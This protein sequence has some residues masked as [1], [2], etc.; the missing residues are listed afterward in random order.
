M[1]AV[2][3]HPKIYHITHIDN[4]SAIAFSGKLISDATRVKKDIACT[5]IGLATLKHR[6]LE[7]IEVTVHPK[8]KVGEYVPF[9]FCPRSVMLY[10][11]H[12]G[13]HTDLPYQG[14]QQNI[15]HLQADL[16]EVVQRA[17]AK[18][19]PWAFSNGN[20]SA[21]VSRYFNRLED[22]TEIDWAAVETKDFREPQIKA[23]KQAEFLTFDAF[24]WN[25]IRKIGTINSTVA[26]EVDRILTGCPHRP[27][28]EIKRDWYY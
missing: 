7:K 4:L 16:R 14:G 10:F 26:T 28:I 5:Q 8:T 19:H 27:T 6:R 24:P 12:M 1:I 3:T 20:A 2:P 11:I 23:K 15:I 21:Y 25:L 22:L 13:N 17:D 9:Y 18:P